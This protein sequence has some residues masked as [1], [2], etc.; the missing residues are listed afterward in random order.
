MAAL[1][2]TKS[3]CMHR[4]ENISFRVLAFLLAS[5]LIAS[6]AVEEDAVPDALPSLYS[7][8][9]IFGSEEIDG[10]ENI[11]KTRGSGPADGTLLN[12]KTVEY[13]KEVE[14]CRFVLIMEEY[15]GIESSEVSDSAAFTRTSSP[16]PSSDDLDMGVYAYV[17]PKGTEA[18]PP[19]YDGGKSA[20]FM[21][22]QFVDI[23]DG[24]SYSPVK[25]WPGSGYWINFF[26]YCPYKS[27]VNKGTTP[28]LGV[29]ASG[30]EP[31]LSYS[32]PQ[33]IDH[34]V[35]LLVSSIETLDGNDRKQVVFQFEHLLSA[36][37][38][39]IGSIPA[40]I[41][42]ISLNDV[43][44]NGLSVKMQSGSVWEGTDNPS[45]F[46]QTGL[47]LVGKDNSG[48]QIGKT[49]YMLPQQFTSDSE[50]SITL[51][52]EAP[53]DD[54]K[55]EFHQY[56]LNVPLEDFCKEWQQGKTYVYTI[57]APKEV[58]VDVEE[59]FEPY[60]RVK[61]NVCFKNTG[62]A[63][64]R[65]RAAIVGYWIVK[66]EVNGVV[67]ECVIGGWDPE[68][69]GEFVGFPGTGWTKNNVDG[70]YY[71]S[72][73]ISPHEKTS[74]LFDSYTLTGNPPAA[75]AELVLNV[76]GQSV[77]AGY[78]GQSWTAVSGN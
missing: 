27:N 78:E 62:L 19:V 68:N 29:N 12:H 41:T 74:N 6:C 7:D 65:V 42:E 63:D 64:I 45:D 17:T 66:S 31:S 61:E 69:D 60:G 55:H 44:Q 4:I 49:F 32:V 56:V 48:K 73:S 40:T 36:V 67:E 52:F 13:E 22:D 58:K 26:A 57:T 59:D 24:Y 23:S 46:V 1:Q 72:S 14:G 11:T 53:K 20:E 39:K 9:L 35:D 34:Q 77:M 8:E 16:I 51:R 76:L 43:C 25:Y 15:E 21:V 2:I 70:F 33:N 75:G 54:S 18:T 50:L 3:K 37:I 30:K 10:W 47:D 28:Y 5:V 38:F 71:Y